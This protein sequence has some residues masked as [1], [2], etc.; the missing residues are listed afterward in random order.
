[1][2]AHIHDKGFGQLGERRGHEPLDLRE[3][4]ARLWMC[5]H[6]GVNL[7]AQIPVESFQRCPQETLFAG[8][9]LVQ[10]L[11][12]DAQ[13]LD[14]GVDRHRVGA[15]GKDPPTKDRENS[16]GRFVGLHRAAPPSGSINV[17]KGRTLSSNDPS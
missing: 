10:G 2:M 7:I 5:S 4:F 8:E 11:F 1:M 12:A 6:D 17:L 15:F 13:F 9:V 14:D 16:L 3:G